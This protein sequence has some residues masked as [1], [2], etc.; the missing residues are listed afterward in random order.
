[1][2]RVQSARSTTV[3]TVGDLY[4]QT[5]DIRYKDI[6]IGFGKLSFVL[7]GNYIKGDTYRAHYTIERLLRELS[8]NTGVVKTQDHVRNWRR[9]DLGI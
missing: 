5:F 7:I 6:D 8:R 9:C 2:R 4:K 1:M 3:D